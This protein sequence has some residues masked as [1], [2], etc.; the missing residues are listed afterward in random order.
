ME[1]DNNQNFNYNLK[2]EIVDHLLET[3]KGDDLLFFLYLK[4]HAVLKGD[5]LHVKLSKKP[6]LYQMVRSNLDKRNLNYYEIPKPYKFVVQNPQNLVNQVYAFME[7]DN[8]KRLEKKDPNDLLAS[9]FVVKG[10]VNTPKSKYYHLEIRLDSEEQFI[11]VSNILRTINIT[12]KVKKEGSKYKLYLKNSS[13]ISDILKFMNAPKAVMYFEDIRIERDFLSS[14][15]KINSID[16][17]N[18]EKTTA[19]SHTQKQ[20]ILKIINSSLFTNLNENKQNIAKLRLDNLHLS[21]K[22]LTYKYN[23]MY[24]THFSKSAIYHWLREIHELALNFE[25]NKKEF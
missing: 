11:Y 5:K 4:F 2:Q 23:Q 7:Q 3:S 17:Y 14:L 15:T 20:D 6:Y 16:V 24:G 19:A 25:K 8:L 22:E 1:F 10:Y 13:S 9:F 12:T 18:A 21:L